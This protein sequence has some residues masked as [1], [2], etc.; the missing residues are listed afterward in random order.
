M[1]NVNL[2]LSDSEFIEPD[3][4]LESQTPGDHSEHGDAGTPGGGGDENSEWEDG[5]DGDIDGELAAELDRELEGDEDEEDDEDESE[6]ENE[7]D[8][9][10]NDETLTS[11]PE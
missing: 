4:T 11:T 5:A 7:E 2:D 3:D 9:D 6:D 10:E 8:D 1:D